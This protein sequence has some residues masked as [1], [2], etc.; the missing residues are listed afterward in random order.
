MFWLNALLTAVRPSFKC[1]RWHTC[2]CARRICLSLASANSVHCRIIARPRRTSRE[3]SRACLSSS[4]ASMKRTLSLTRHPPI[5]GLYSRRVPRW[6]RENSL[7][8]QSVWWQTSTS[9]AGIVTMQSV[10]PSVWMK[11]NSRAR[12]VPATLKSRDRLIQKYLRMR[13]ATPEMQ[14]R[15]AFIA[16]PRSQKWLGTTSS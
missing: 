3:E 13:L 11:R 5:E 16:D 12:L 8:N 15:H 10:C 9:S 7:L 6:Y 4:P 1:L 14:A 2:R